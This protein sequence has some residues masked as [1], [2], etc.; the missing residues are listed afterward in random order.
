[1]TEQPK[2]ER[3]ITAIAVSG[4]KS[5][6]DESRIEIRN[7][8]VLAGAN[9]SGKSSIMQPLLLLKQTLE[10]PYDA[11]PLKLDGPNVKFTSA[12]QFLVASP[13]TSER[14][15]FISEIEVNQQRSISNTYT[16]RSETPKIELVKTIRHLQSRIY[17]LRSNMTSDEITRQIPT[18]YFRRVFQNEPKGSIP[19]SN[20]RVVLK[21]CF[22]DAALYN[23]RDNSRFQ[24]AMYNVKWGIS[25]NIYLTHLIHLP[26]IRGNPE[27]AYPT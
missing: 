14:L 20:W 27:R 17:E 19:D 22:L 24:G 26:G 16:K 4:F 25:P 1:M 15:D 7:L 3:G 13:R 2:E 11:G 18:G 10:A 5:L 9:S 23:E 8:T 12:E 6:R 21:Q